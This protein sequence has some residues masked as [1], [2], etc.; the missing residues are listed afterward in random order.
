MTGLKEYGSI[1]EERETL[2]SQEIEELLTPLQDWRKGEKAESGTLHRATYAPQKI[3]QWKYL[4][5][6]A[7]GLVFVDD[8]RGLACKLL[9]NKSEAREVQNRYDKLKG[10]LRLATLRYADNGCVVTDFQYGKQITDPNVLSE[11][12]RIA[13]KI[14]VRLD[15]GKFNVFENTEGY[16]TLVDY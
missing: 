9:Y 6:G 1:G 12:V 16:P 7:H 5:R 11:M 4:D 15:R 3:G 13:E 10:S 8:T 14:G 2:S